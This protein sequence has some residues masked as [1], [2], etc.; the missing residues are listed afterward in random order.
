MDE[1]A[2]ALE[3][4]TDEK[5]FQARKPMGGKER[6]LWMGQGRS[7][8]W[9][10]RLQ[11]PKPSSLEAIRSLPQ[12]KRSLMRKIKF[13]YSIKVKSLWIANSE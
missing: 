11:L 1:S 3:A 12:N 5:G 9:E 2:A 4:K 8:W 7:L 10:K 6:R 13:V